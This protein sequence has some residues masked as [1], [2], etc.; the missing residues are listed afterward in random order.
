MTI[1]KDQEALQGLGGPMTRAR[2][3]KAKEA[4]QQVLTTI[5]E[6]GSKLEEEKPKMKNCIMDKEDHFGVETRVV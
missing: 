5:F 1:G 6:E 4:L 2:A 3:R